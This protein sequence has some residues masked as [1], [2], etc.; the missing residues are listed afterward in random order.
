MLAVVAAED[1]LDTLD[2][3]RSAGHDA[4]LVGEIVE[5]R[6]RVSIATR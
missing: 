6:G 5:G 4:W 1:R 3:I 2:H